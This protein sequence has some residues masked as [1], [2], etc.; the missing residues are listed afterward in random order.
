LLSLFS[1]FQVFFNAKR[2]A[3]RLHRITKRR[4]AKQSSVQP[5]L[6][7]GTEYGE[8]EVTQLGHLGGAI[9]G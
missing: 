2:L 3:T 9:E 1:S 8:L 6:C 7:H 4:R 5:V